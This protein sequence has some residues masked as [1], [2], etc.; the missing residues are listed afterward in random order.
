MKYIT[1]Y[2]R[3]YRILMIVAP[4]LMVGE[5]ICDLLLPYLMSFIVNY[6]IIGMSVTDAQEG[7]AV[8]AQI[9][10]LLFGS[11]WTRTHLIVSF[12]I[13]MMLITVIGGFFG[14]MCSFVTQKA[15]QGF[16]HD[17]RC[18]TFGK[19]MSLSIEQTD[20][21]TTGSL[22]TRLTNDV[23][24]VI[25]FMQQLLRSFVRPP[26]FMFGGMV[27]LFSLNA[28]FG[29]IVLVSIP[30]MGVLIYIVLKKAL[31]LFNEA[32]ERLD[33]LNLIVQENVGG[34]RV[35]K[36]YV[37]EE[38]ECE[39]FALANQNLKRVNLRVFKLMASVSPAMKF[40]MNYAVLLVIFIG[41]RSIGLGGAMT[42]G[43]IMAAVTYTTQ[44]IRS[45]IMASNLLQSITR[46]QVSA[47]RIEA[48]LG[49]APVITDGTGIDG[50]GGFD[51]LNHREED[52]ADDDAVIF[53]DVSFAYP[54]APGQP[55]LSHI[56]LHIR[57]GETFAIIGSTGCGKT[58]LIS[59]I[60]RFYDA[61]Q[62][63]V[64]INR[65]NVRDFSQHELRKKIG[66]VMQKSELFSATAKENIRLGKDDASDEEIRQAAIDAQADEFISAKPDGYDTFIAERGNSLS[67]GQKQRLSVARA[68]VRKP[69]ILILDDATSALDLATES[70][71][72]A[73]LNE[74]YADT[75]V[76]MVAQRIASVREADR[77]AVIEN[78][79]TC[80]FCASHDDL[81]KIS[82]TYRE[83]YD[84]QIKTGALIEK[85][86][87]GES[88]GAV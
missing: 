3:P 32:Q 43:A 44:S 61:T 56:N 66:Y 64:L 74:R 47:A 80:R 12:G 60:P 63:A 55:V 51:R 15:A 7:S 41:C 8:A 11:E 50:D 62:G 34:A 23:T 76:I 17:L 25:E 1:K 19:I 75:T 39:Q 82:A 68:L 10:S 31:P 33:H 81:M 29:G 73:A 36:A 54:D 48:V 2:V 9:L 46:A 69:E 40:V 70:K 57:R 13:L 83:I 58:S 87:G 30:I 28:G 37:R 38:F 52:D 67:G 88:K 53:D 78:D 5:V 6:G 42:T 16:G 77:I 22:V 59:L 45:L 20:S 27:M 21:F 65:R 26:M 85:A 18:A 49:T 71:L 24:M 14:V 72:H 84:S 86:A 79:G 4:L 35:I